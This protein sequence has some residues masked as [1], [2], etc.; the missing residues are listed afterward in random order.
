MRPLS[1]Y[2]VEA[3]NSYLHAGF[4]KA[5]RT[6]PVLGSSGL[7]AQ[8][9][10]NVRETDTRKVR[11]TMRQWQGYAIKHGRLAGPGSSESS[12]WTDSRWS[13]S[14]RALGGPR[15]IASRRFPPD[16]A[17]RPR[18]DR[19]SCR[20][21]PHEMKMRMRRP[22]TVRGRHVAEPGAE[23]RLEGAARDRRATQAV[24]AVDREERAC[25]ERVRDETRS[26]T[27]AQSSFSC[28]SRPTVGEKG[29]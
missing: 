22:R 9:G 26:T 16:R 15:S 21:I 24:R 17:N 2:Q 28:S 12:R 10:C 7:L 23:P 6:V 14:V 5:D 1:L 11:A 29:R 13:G 19:P 3:H 4:G 20:A 25:L 18:T 27:N 8:I